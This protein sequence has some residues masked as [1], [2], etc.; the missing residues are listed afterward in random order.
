MLK[1]TTLFCASLVFALFQFLSLSS[2]SPQGCFIMDFQKKT[3]SIPSYEDHLQKINKLPS[4]IVDIDH[5]D[6]IGKVSKYVYGN[7]V[8]PYMTQMITES[9]LLSNLRKLSTNNLRF[10]GGNIFAVGSKQ[11]RIGQ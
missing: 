4:V 7:N 5:T 9:I 6:T 2:Q 11:R 8:N 10:P 1:K 3:A